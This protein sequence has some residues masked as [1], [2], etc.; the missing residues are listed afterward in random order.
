V[1]EDI[2]LRTRERA[3]GFP[4]T[5]PSNNIPTPRERAEGFPLVAGG[6]NNSAV[7]E[8]IAPTTQPNTPSNRNDK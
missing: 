2:L 7:P 6:M 4:T 8:P 1:T 5:V 3:E